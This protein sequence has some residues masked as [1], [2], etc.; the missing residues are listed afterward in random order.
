MRLLLV[1][2]QHHQFINILLQMDGESTSDLTDLDSEQLDDDVYD[3]TPSNATSESSSPTPDPSHSL[4]GK[5]RRRGPKTRAIEAWKHAREHLPWEDDQ[6]KHGQRIYYCK[7]CDWSGVI[8]N[9]GRHLQHKH[10]ILVIEDSSLRKRAAHNAIKAGFTVQEQK[11]QKT[12]DTK[13]KN[14]LKSAFKKDQYEDAVARLIARGSLNHRLIEL[15]EWAAVIAAV[16]WTASKRLNGSHASIPPRIRSNFEREQSIIKGHLQQSI[17]AIHLCTDSWYAGRT[18][19]REFQGINAQWVNLEGRLQKALLCLPALA[20]GHAGSEVAPHLIKA[21]EFYNIEGRLG[22]IT[23]DNHGA[24]DTLCRELEQH[25]VTKGINWWTADQRRLRCFGHIIQLPTN[26]FL[27]AKDNEA[28][29]LALSRAANS[30]SQTMDEAIVLLSEVDDEG[31]SKIPTL[32][33]VNKFA[34][35]LRNLRLHKQWMAHASQRLTKPNETRWHGWLTLVEQAGQERPAYAALCNEVPELEQYYLTPDEWQLLQHTYHFL[36][37]FK[38]TCKRAEGDNVTL[39]V[40]QQ[41]MDFLRHHYTQQEIKHTSNS[42]LLAAINTSWL[43]FNKYYE[44]IDEVAA[45]VTAVLLHPSKRKAYLN[46]HWKRAWIKPGIDRARRLWLEYKERYPYAANELAK[47]DTF[48]QE[49]SAY[50]LY[51]RQMDV[52]PQGDDFDTFI[53]AP[54]TKLATESSAIS[55]W[56]SADQ[57]AAYPALSQLAVDVLS[58]LVMSAHSERTFSQARRTTSWQRTRLEEETVEQSE[59]CK[60]WQCSGLAYKPVNQEEASDTTSGDDEMAVDSIE[61]GTLTLS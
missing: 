50:E 15:P 10:G 32:Q 19:Q 41:E 21:L 7:H 17:S 34:T 37:P 30:E 12:M 44:L 29:Q 24:N 36:Q 39:D 61:D 4:F 11:A 60:D 13:V 9:S 28:A 5:K 16:N 27:Y 8:Q 26:A 40:V 38:E 43:L 31:W 57:R 56:S 51:L 2:Q 58:A 1:L 14:I 47:S 35:A 48:D 45:Y 22:W 55:W 53:D 20:E 42:G 3:T 54:P 25:L 59:C 52:L 23:G 46:K 49:P 33:K 6:N 18:L